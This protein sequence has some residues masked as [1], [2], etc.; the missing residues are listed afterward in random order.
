MAI[1]LVPLCTVDAV[2]RDPID[3]GV[4]P[5]GWRMVFEVAEGTITGERLSGSMTGMAAADWV[6][7]GGTVGVID[8]R[9]TVRTDDG[10]LVLVTY[11]GRTDASAGGGAPIYVAPTFETGDERYDWLN[12]VQAVGKGLTEGNTLRYEWYE[13]R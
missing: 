1:E 10:A 9:F 6:A 4:G 2:L 8:V 7:V 13:V 5:K 11:G 3:V 12:A